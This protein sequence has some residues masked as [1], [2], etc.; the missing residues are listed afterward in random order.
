MGIGLPFT[1][2]EKQDAMA[3]RLARSCLLKNMRILRSHACEMGWHEITG[4]FEVL[5]FDHGWQIRRSRQKGNEEGEN[6]AHD[7]LIFTDF[8]SPIYPTAPVLFGRVLPAVLVLVLV[9]CVLCAVKWSG[10]AQA[11]HLLR[12]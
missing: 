3:R 12:R 1:Q 11:P 9:C 6:G 8:P 4:K 2:E 5:Q 7:A 10:L